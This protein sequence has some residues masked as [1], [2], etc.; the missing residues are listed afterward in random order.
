MPNL[1]FLTL[2][3]H[4]WQKEHQDNKLKNGQTSYTKIFDKDILHCFTFSDL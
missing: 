1:H 3:P 4:Y 2:L